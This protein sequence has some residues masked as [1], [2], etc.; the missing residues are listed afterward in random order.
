MKKRIYASTGF[1]MMFF[2]F[3][4]TAETPSIQKEPYK[5]MQFIP[6]GIDMH[7]D[8][9]DLTI[10]PAYRI[11]TSSGDLVLRVPES[12]HQPHVVR[13]KPGDYLV[14]VNYSGEH[15]RFRIEVDNDSFQQFRMK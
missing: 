3:S 8:G 12:R 15:K 10:Y 14:E 7:F 5:T 13:I 1:I 11:L 9:Y 2:A 4:L 6:E